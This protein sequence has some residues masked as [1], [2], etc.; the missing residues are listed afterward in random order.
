M[1]AEF[2]VLNQ[3]CY[4]NTATSGIL[5][6][7]LLNWRKQHDEEF[8]QD[9][10]IFRLNKDE[11]LEGVRATVA[12]FFYAKPEN[13]FLVP[14]FSYG[15]STFLAGLSGDHRFLLLQEDYPSVTYPV[16]NSGFAYDEV[17]IDENLEANILTKI[18]LF[19]PTVLA[20][21]LVQYQDGLKI[22]LEFLK[23]LK[24][25]YPNLIIVAD[26]TQYCGTED[27]NFERSGIDVLIAS[28]YKWMLGGYG[29]GFV[30]IK[31]QV[32]ALLYRQA[33]TSPHPGELFLQGKTTLGLFFEPG[34]LDTLSFGSLQQSILSLNKMGIGQIEKQI[35]AISDIA[36][37][38]FC[39][40]GLL[41]PKVLKRTAHSSIFKLDVPEHLLEKLTA[42]GIVYTYRGNGIRVSFHFYNTTGDLERLLA[43]IDSCS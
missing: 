1:P 18:E 33:Q 3:Y 12:G 32:A 14:N 30:L 29:N 6:K 17:T 41:S 25:R 7:T 35:K 20:L 9:G 19:G 39:E 21:S 36:K 4:L 23:K 43:V 42:A 15:F 31:D 27:F 8:H 38:G 2:P 22:D 11:F 5:S 28:G 13:T 37:A 26:G 10:S 16:R 24:D 34:H 40:R